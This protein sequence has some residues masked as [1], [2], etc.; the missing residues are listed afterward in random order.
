MSGGLRTLQAQLDRLQHGFD[1]AYREPVPE[2][3]SELEDL[4][5]IE[6]AGHPYALRV[7]ELSGLYEERAV[8]ALPGSPSELLGL[9]AVR[10]GLVAVYNLASL[11]GYARDELPRLFVTVR[12]TSLAFAFRTLAGHRRV[13]PDQLAKRESEHEQDHDRGHEAWSVE[14]MREPDQSRPILELS[15][16]VRE[17]ERRWTVERTME[18]D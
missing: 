13:T 8:T 7:R 12:G 10:G 1:D 16:L 3:A 18:G 15:A 4:L 6:I 5:A 2:R 9:A 11:I 17:L 14:V